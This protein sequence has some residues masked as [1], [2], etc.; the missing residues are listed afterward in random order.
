L[1]ELLDE[2]SFGMQLLAIERKNACPKY[3][4]NQG[5]QLDTLGGLEKYDGFVE[6]SAAQ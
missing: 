6:S 2:R 3:W 1:K 5:T 4:K